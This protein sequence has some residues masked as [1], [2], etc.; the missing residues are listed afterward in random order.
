MSCAGYLWS[1]ILEGPMSHRKWLQS[2]QRPL[3]GTIELEL[4][5]EHCSPEMPDVLTTS[6]GSN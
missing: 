1:L 3:A 2:Q 6:A 4:G 5:V